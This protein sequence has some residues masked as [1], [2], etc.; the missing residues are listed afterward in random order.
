[1]WLWKFGWY[2]IKKLCIIINR[3]NKRLNSIKRNLKYIINLSSLFTQTIKLDIKLQSKYFDIKR[4]RLSPV[5]TMSIQY[6]FSITI[7][8]C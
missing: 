6:K 3:I 7:S 2:L 5:L 1:M 8:L 4:I